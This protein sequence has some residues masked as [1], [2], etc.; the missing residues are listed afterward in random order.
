VNFG[1]QPE[2]ASEATADGQ[3]STS[4]RVESPL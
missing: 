3:G 1:S 4:T 2:A